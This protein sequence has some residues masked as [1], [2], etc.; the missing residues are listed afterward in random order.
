MMPVINQ[1][2][3][4]ETPPPTGDPV[5]SLSDFLT[6]SGEWHKKTARPNRG[7][8]SE[9]WY[10]GVSQPYPHQTPGV[11][12]EEFS[13]RA[14]HLQVGGGIKKRRLYLECGISCGISGQGASKEFR[15]LHY[16]GTRGRRPRVLP[17]C[18][19]QSRRGWI[20]GGGAPAFRV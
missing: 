7:L 10:R 6:A 17:N 3:H 9:I 2:P 18:R 1:L 8:L 16:L 4:I 11:Y 14:K 19:R 13:D 5:K 12:R 20:V 15:D